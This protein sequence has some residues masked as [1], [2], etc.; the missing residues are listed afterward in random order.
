M[1]VFGF[2]GEPLSGY[3]RRVPDCDRPHTTDPGAGAGCP[4]IPAQRKAPRGD[5]RTQTHCLTVAELCTWLGLEKDYVIRAGVRAGTL[6]HLR[7]GRK[8]RF[9]P[10]HVAAIMRQFE[11]QPGGVAVS[12]GGVDPEGAASGGGLPGMSSRSRAAHGI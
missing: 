2:A 11:R 12:S 3:S 5:P 8:I 10:E 4:P 6:P 7:I 1:G 9:A